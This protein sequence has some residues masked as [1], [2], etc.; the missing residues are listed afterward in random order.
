MQS[1]RSAVVR[2]G[3]LA[4]LSVIAAAIVVIACAGSGSVDGFTPPGGYAAVEASG[5]AFDPKGP[6][7]YLSTAGSDSAYGQTPSDAVQTINVGLGLAAACPGAPCY[8]KV[9]AGRLPG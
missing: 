7:I 8:V 9:A 2:V 4:V 1:S 3:V 6:T 5:P